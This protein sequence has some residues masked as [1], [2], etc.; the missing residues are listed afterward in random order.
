[1]AHPD[2]DATNHC[3]AKRYDAA[4]S[5]ARSYGARAADLRRAAAR[6]DLTFGDITDVT[7]WRELSLPSGVISRTARCARYVGRTGWESQMPPPPSR[8]TTSFGQSSTSPRESVELLRGE[9]IMLGEPR[10]SCTRQVLRKGDRPLGRHQPPW[11]IKTMDS[12]RR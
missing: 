9:R 3:S 5:R 6:D 4:V 8:P 11:F 2:D 7:W 10:P 12:D 1:M